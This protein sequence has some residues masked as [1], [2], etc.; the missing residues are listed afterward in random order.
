MNLQRRRTRLMKT[1]NMNSN[2]LE[3]VVAS[4]LGYHSGMKEGDRKKL[5]N[6]ARKVIKGV[7]GG[8][9]DYG[10]ADVVEAHLQAIACFEKPLADVTQSMEALAQKL[11]VADWVRQPEQ[12]GF[13]WLFLAIVI[14]ETGDLANY[15]NPAKVW[16]RMGCAPFT[17]DGK[18]LMGATWKSGKNGK[19]TSEAWSEFGYSPRRRSIAYQIGANF[20]MQNFLKN[21]KGNGDIPAVTDR[22]GVYHSRAGESTN[23]TESPGAGTNGGNGH[24]EEKVV[25]GNLS[26]GPYRLR[27]DEAKAIMKT[28]HP[29]YPAQRCHLHGML[30]ATKLLLKNLWVEWNKGGGGAAVV[31]ERASAAP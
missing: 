30:L 16:R 9:S 31:A 4:D 18:T 25:N 3:A 2:R 6:E 21:G 26:A 17:F 20:M 24:G 1:R 8:E 19:L 14:G 5:F 23:V 28:N 29:D 13:K 12:R 7:D 27:Y 15:A 22:I 10:Y 11:P